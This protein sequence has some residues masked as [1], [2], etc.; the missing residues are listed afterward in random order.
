MNRLHLDFTIEKVEDRV[1]FVDSYL[2]TLSFTPNEDEL[3]T[4][5]NYIL[6]GKDING[7]NVQQTGAIHIKDWDPASTESLE[8]LAEQPA[9]KETSF[10]SL[11]YPA[12]KLPKL[13]FNRSAALNSAPSYIIP[14]FQE[15]FHE[16]D[17]IELLINYY[18]IKHGRRAIEP[19]EALLS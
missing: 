15:L 12:T 9:I 2:S 5:S 4:I 10:H 16:I 13:Q 7:Q 6:W 8:D 1:S 18:D 3:E 17:T 19:R 14:I 11:S